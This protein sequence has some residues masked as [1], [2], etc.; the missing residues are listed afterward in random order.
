MSYLE[1]YLQGLVSLGHW[2]DFVSGVDSTQFAEWTE[3][4]LTGPTVELQD[5]ESIILG[6]EPSHPGRGLQNCGIWSPS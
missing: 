6:S 1:S 4:P 3:Q 2:E 5:C